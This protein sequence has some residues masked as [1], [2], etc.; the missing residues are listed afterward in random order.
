MEINACDS[1]PCLNRGECRKFDQF[2]FKC[3]CPYGW[4]GKI[5]EQPLY[6]CNDTGKCKN[7]GLCMSN[8]NPGHFICFCPPDFHG[9]QCQYKYNECQPNDCQNGATCLDR[10]NGYSC[11]CPIGFTGEFCE[12]DCLKQSINNELCS[13]HKNIDDNNTAI[14]EPSISSISTIINIVPTIPVS[15]QSS[16]SISSSTSNILPNETGTITIVR[17][18]SA[19]QIPL[20]L[21]PDEIDVNDMNQIYA[22]SFN[23]IDSEILFK[24]RRIKRST[25]SMKMIFVSQNDDDGGGMNH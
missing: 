10:V 9:N 13:I 22:P 14:I 8:G 4:S 1:S 12:I 5:C 18:T 17:P 19:I 21:I 16:S 2:D 20:L 11:R 24:M 7:N 25:S 23:G 15:I 6:K 3:N